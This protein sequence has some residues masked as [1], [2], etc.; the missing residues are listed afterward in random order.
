MI[1]TTTDM[2]RTFLDGIKKA[3]TSIVNPSAFN[4]IINSWGQD[5]W[6]QANAMVAEL[7]SKQHE[8]MEKIRVATDGLYTYD[9]S[10]IF[11]ISPDTSQSYVFSIPKH[12]TTVNVRIADGSVVSDVLP[13]YLRFL[14]VM[15]KI[16]YGSE[17]ECDLTGESGW[18]KADIMKSDQRP[19]IE[20]NPLRSPKDSRLYYEMIDGKIRLITGT[21]SI[22]YSM[23]LEY[24]RYPIEI[25]FNESAPTDTGVPATGSVMCEFAPEQVKEIVDTAIRV[26]LERVK[27]PRYQS[28]L[29]EEKIRQEIR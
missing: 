13:K 14:N 26:Y 19:V 5:E 3:E 10:I 1:T 20:N 15:F 2:Y 8:D 22:G 11:P 21:N 18:L 16:T 27:D 23:R 6:I 24:F 28:F 12:N 29:N 25:F 9:S 4:R 7:T 17:N